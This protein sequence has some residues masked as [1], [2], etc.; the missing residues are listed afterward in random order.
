MPADRFCL[1]SVTVIQTRDTPQRVYLKTVFCM[2]YGA[3]AAQD[4]ID[5]SLINDPRGENY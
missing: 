1:A 3:T 2:M 5:L 4:P